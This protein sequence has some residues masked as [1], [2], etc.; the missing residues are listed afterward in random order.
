MSIPDQLISMIFYPYLYLPFFVKQVWRG[1]R[2]RLDGKSNVSLR[3]PSRT[4][5]R[6]LVRPDQSLA[7]PIL[8]F[9]SR[10]RL[11]SRLGR[12]A[13]DEKRGNT[14]AGPKKP[15]LR[16][17]APAQQVAW[18]HRHRSRSELEKLC[19][20]VTNESHRQPILWGVLPQGTSRC[21]KS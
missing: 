10:A 8:G 6:R 20:P 19:P 11:G 16:N 15:V 18:G 12:T 5:C 9:R 2:G 14:P 13:A 4:R 1:T 21:Q 17:D 3:R 7:R